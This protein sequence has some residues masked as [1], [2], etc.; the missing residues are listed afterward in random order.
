M[1]SQR[2]KYYFDQGCKWYPFPHAGGLRAQME[3]APWSQRYS[4]RPRKIKTKRMGSL[5]DYLKARPP[6]NHPRPFDST[7][8]DFSH[9]NSE[10]IQHKKLTF[11]DWAHPNENLDM[12]I[13]RKI[14]RPSWIE[15]N[16]RSYRSVYNGE[17]DWDYDE[18]GW[19]IIN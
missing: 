16:P 19:R 3:Q 11:D 4:N 15:Q 1:S 12:G 10:V 17:D 7:S 14:R 9:I 18:L 2:F 8:V 13:L 5:L 6:P